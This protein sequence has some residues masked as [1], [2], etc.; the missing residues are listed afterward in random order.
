MK[1][2]LY[3]EKEYKVKINPSSMFDV[4]VKRIHEYKRQLMNCL[5]IIT[6]YNRKPPWARRGP[7][8][9]PGVQ[10]HPWPPGAAAGTEVTPV[11]PSPPGIKRDPTK[12]F[13]PR[14]VIIGG[15]VIWV[16]GKPLE[17]SYGIWV[18]ALSPVGP[19]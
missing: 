14:T 18:Q 11:L 12:L 3:L 5:H 9:C 19:R 6:M 7:T 8:A 2:A 1:F 16:W 10:E 4:H 15:K 13:V 17:T